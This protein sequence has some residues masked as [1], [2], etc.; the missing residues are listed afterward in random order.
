MTATSVITVHLK[1]LYIKWYPNHSWIGKNEKLQTNFCGANTGLK[2][3]SLEVHF[4]MENYPSLIDG[5]TPLKLSPL[6]LS[7]CSQNKS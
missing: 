2:K 1:G 6:N 7:W 5:T 3:P 4:F